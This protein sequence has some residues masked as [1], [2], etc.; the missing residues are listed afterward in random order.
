MVRGR[1]SEDTVRESTDAASLADGESHTAPSDR[2]LRE[3]A[4]SHL[5]NAL[6][7]NTPSEKN[8]HIRSALQA[9]MIE[10]ENRL[11]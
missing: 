10:E 4:S 6:E 11:D 3:L 1:D 9:L 7:T 8:Y 2:R 5:Q